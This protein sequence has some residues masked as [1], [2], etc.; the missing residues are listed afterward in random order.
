MTNRIFDRSAPGVRLTRVP[1][2]HARHG[3]I[4]NLGTRLVGL[5][6]EDTEKKADRLSLQLDNHDLTLFD[7]DALRGGTVLDVS[8]GYPAQ[9]ALPRRVV[10]KKLK[11][12]KT[13]TVEAYALSMLMSQRARSR[14]WSQVTR[15]EVARQI[16]KVQGYDELHIDVDETTERFDVINQTAE[17]DARFLRRLA[18]REG[19]EMYIDAQGFHFHKRRQH[20]PPTHTFIWYAD[21]GRGDI[22][23]LH[24]ETDLVRRVG[25]V[26]VRGRD[27]LHRKTIEASTTNETATRATLGEVIEVVDP[28]TGRTALELRN[29]TE[30]VHPT[31]VANPRRAEQVAQARFRKAEQGSV[32]LSMQVVGDPTLS[33]KSII[34]V[35]GISR[36]L[37]GK[38]YVREV[39]HHVASTGYVSRLK[40]TRDGMGR[41]MQT[42]EQRPQGGVR[43]T[44]K[45]RTDD[46]LTQLEVVDPE[47]GETHIEYRRDGRPLGAGDPEVGARRKP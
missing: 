16:A 23:S 9:M 26:T 14:S 42:D 17:T 43:N 13:L 19:F 38:Y 46:G 44:A 7:H 4:L 20:T 36:R 24:V 15:S 32:R 31:S 39:R 21:P 34:E 3:E 1:S 35:H 28:E 47:T 41:H 2:E 6:F 11:G 33:A 8:W 5:T 25:R 30:S 22:L 27:P 12:F 18:T 40:L 10:V 29:A 45:P 37:S